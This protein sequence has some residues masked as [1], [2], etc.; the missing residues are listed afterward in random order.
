[1]QQLLWTVFP[2]SASVSPPPGRYHYTNATH[3]ASSSGPVLTDWQKREAWDPSRKRNALSRNRKA[4]SSNSTLRRTILSWDRVTTGEKSH[5]LD[6]TW[7]DSTPKLTDWPID[8]PS[9]SCKVTTT[10]QPSKGF[11]LSAE[12]KCKWQLSKPAVSDHSQRFWL[13][14]VHL[15]CITCWQHM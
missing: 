5:S 1:M 13:L 11:N 2:P 9:V 15:H 3:S 6:R 7:W 14:A 4:S 10:S 8:W 12:F